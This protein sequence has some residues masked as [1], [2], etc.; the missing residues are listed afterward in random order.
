MR[1]YLI[2]ILALAT[3]FQVFAQTSKVGTIDIDYILSKMPELANVKTGVETYGKELDTELGEKI[4]KYDS[5]VKGYT[6][7]QATYGNEIK[8]TKQKEIFELEDEMQQFRQNS[9]TLLQ[10]KQNE[11]MQPLY[12][13]VG[14]ALEVVAKEQGYSQVLTSNQTVAYLD[15]QFDLT[16]AVMKKLG[17]PTEEN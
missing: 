6:A 14:E 16:L 12:K 9:V 11:L 5:L 10:L 7:N 8:K 4:A 2:G 15:P 17:L 3:S 13:K 1:Y